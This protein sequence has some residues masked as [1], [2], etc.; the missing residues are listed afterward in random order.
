MDDLRPELGCY[1]NTVVKTPNID[2]LAARGLVFTHAYCQQA[3]CSPSRSSLLT[4][5]YPTQTG[6]MDN[7]QWWGYRHPDYTSLPRWF[8]DHG[9]NTITEGKIF[10]IGIDDTDAWTEGG[11]RRRYAPSAASA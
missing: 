7:R 4:G 10:H 6:V 11:A 3:V 8:K 1:G 2:K 9:Y 5:H